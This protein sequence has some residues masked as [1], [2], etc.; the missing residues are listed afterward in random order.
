MIATN[1][2]NKGAVHRLKKFLLQPPNLLPF[3]YL[4][5]TY[6]PRLFDFLAT[7]NHTTVHRKDNLFSSHLPAY[8]KK[9]D[10]RY[11]DPKARNG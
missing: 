10:R 8:L 11:S 3:L 7:S 5:S 6:K 4:L 9:Q 1:F 2:V